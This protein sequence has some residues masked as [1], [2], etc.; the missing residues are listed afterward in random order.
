M[1]I[2]GRTYIALCAVLA[3]VPALAQPAPPPPAEADAPPPEV[4]PSGAAPVE[5]PPP[6]AAPAPPAPAQ[7]RAQPAAPSAPAG[8]WVYAQQ[9]GWIWMAYGDAYAYAPP[10]GY[11]EPLAYVYY[12]TVGWTWLVAPWVWGIGP[13]P[14]FGA[15]G[16][17]HFGWYARGWWRTPARWHFTP[18]R[19]HGGLASRGVRS[20]PARRERAREGRGERGGERGE[21]HR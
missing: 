11:G 18:A 3:W 21:R 10:S 9:Y 15:I 14:R 4:T 19:I 17:G 6:P 8:Q 7:A 12:P 2:S 5:P 16:P 13:W 20:A 1:M